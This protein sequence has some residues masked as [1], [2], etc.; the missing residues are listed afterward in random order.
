MM[1]LLMTIGADGIVDG[2]EPKPT[3]TPLGGAGEDK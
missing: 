3:I 1:N 2:T